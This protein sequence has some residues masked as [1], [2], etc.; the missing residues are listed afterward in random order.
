[1]GWKGHG[2]GLGKF[3][4][5]ITAPIELDVNRCRLGFGFARFGDGYDEELLELDQADVPTVS[6]PITNLSSNNAAPPP[7]PCQ[8]SQPSNRFNP[9]QGNFN[10]RQQPQQNFSRNKPKTGGFINNIVQ[11]LSNF[12]SSPTENDLIFSNNLSVED[13]KFVHREAHRLGLKTR[14]EGKGDERFLVVQKKRSSNEIVESAL[15]NGGQV[16]KYKII[17]KGDF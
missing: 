9:Q 2:F 11:L 16:S 5:G 15:K 13:R 3:E 10:R 6:L 1:M 8:T 7:Q 12:I 14:S 17:S 4:Q